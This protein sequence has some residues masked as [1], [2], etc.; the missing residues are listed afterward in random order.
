MSNATRVSPLPRGRSRVGPRLLGGPRGGGVT[1]QG[2]G[3]REG[4]LSPRC[5]RR[6][7]HERRCALRTSP[8]SPYVPSL[9]GAVIRTRGVPGRQAHYSAR[10]TGVR[11]QLSR[12][13]AIRPI[14]NGRRSHHKKENPPLSLS[15]PPAFSVSP[16][17][18][19]LSFFPVPVCSGLSGN[20]R[21]FRAAEIRSASR[22]ARGRP[23]GSG[24]HPDTT[25]NGTALPR[26]R[27]LALRSARATG[28]SIAAVNAFGILKSAGGVLCAFP[29]A[30]RRER[31][32]AGRARRHVVWP[33]CAVCVRESCRGESSRTEQRHG[34][35]ERQRR[36]GGALE[37]REGGGGG[38]TGDAM[39]G[40]L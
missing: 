14:H 16:T 33:W 5:R 25:F 23:A 13:C 22:H 30:A 28:L 27:S 17:Y 12:A 6:E 1:G 4:S 2:A 3:A 7:P 20:A 21:R 36:E 39:V 18:S 19:R 40:A 34:R 31:G 35:S 15:L 11:V 38:D 8:T 29:L 24:G 37:P 10:R 32:A 26:P 9:A